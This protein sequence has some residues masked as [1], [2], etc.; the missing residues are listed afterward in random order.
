[1]RP[2]R[3]EYLSP[4][5]IFGKVLGLLGRQVA[6]QFGKVV[7]LFFDVFGKIF[8]ENFETRL[9]LRIGGLSVLK[10]FELFFNL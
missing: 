10:G 7:T 4:A 8:H 9:K 6:F 5:E 2:G 3:D 1:M